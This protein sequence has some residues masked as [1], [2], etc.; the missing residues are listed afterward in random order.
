MRKVLFIAA[1][2]LFA[3]C[4][5]PGTYERL[6]SQAAEEY[7]QPVRPAS[8]GRNPCWNKFAKKFMYAPAFDVP[9]VEGAASYRFTVKGPDGEWSFDAKE[10]GAS[11]AP[12]W[13]SIPPSK[14]S[15][16]VLALDDSGACIDT[17]YTREFLRD[18]P[19]S[20]PYTEPVRDYREAAIKGALYV[21]LMPEVQN[22]I[23]SDAPDMAYSHNTYPCK[24]IGA[25]IRNE[26]FIARELPERRENALQVARSAAAFLI[27]MSRP[28]GDPLAFFPP[29]YY[30]DKQ[31][32][33]REWNKGKTMTLEAAA[34]GQAFLDLYD[35]TGE[36]EYFDRAVGI[37][38]TYIKLQREDGS[39]PIKVDFVTGEPVNEVCAMLHPLLRYFLRLEGYG[40]T[41]FS[42]A[43]EKGER[44]MDEIA[45]ERFDMTGQFEDVNVKGLEPYQNLT[46]CTAAPYA[47]YLMHKSVITDRDRANA[48]DLVRLSEDQF[49]HWAYH[50]LLADGFPRKNAPCVHEQY[51]YEMPVDNSACNVANAWLDIYED[52]GDLLCLAKAKAMIDNITIQQNAVNGK[53]PTTWEWRETGKDRKRTFWINCSFSSVSMLMRF[54]EMQDDIAKLQ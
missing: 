43:R 17:A 34:A 27:A 7:L 30:L 52:S 25:T 53:L 47:S 20:G 19:F 51:H 41:E 38:H 31:A 15:L 12:V 4:A 11:L 9:A 39:L 32:S 49:V 40:M 37:G 6:N 26:C 14:V 8:E 1:L 28:E 36:K 42:P 2:A 35:V 54:A 23:G 33:N 45:V 24:I 48:R 13:N 10:P 18:F 3:A 44:W 5:R 22:W 21:H 16:A 46:N 50:D 29:T